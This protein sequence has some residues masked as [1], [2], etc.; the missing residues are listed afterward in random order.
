MPTDHNPQRRLSGSPERTARD[1]FPLGIALFV[2]SM[3]FFAAFFILVIQARLHPVALTEHALV[4]ALG[5]LAVGAIAGGLFISATRRPR[6]LF[7]HFAIALGLFAMT[8]VLLQAVR[9]VAGVPFDSAKLVATSAGVTMVVGSARVVYCV[10]RVSWGPR[11]A[12]NETDD[13]RSLNHVLNNA[14]TTIYTR[15]LVEPQG[16]A[17]LLDDFAGLLASAIP[18]QGTVLVPVAQELRLIENLAELAGGRGGVSSRV[19][20]SFPSDAVGLVPS[21]VLAT[22]F[23]NAV[24]HGFSPATGWDIEARYREKESGGFL[25]RVVN[26]SGDEAPA[27]AGLGSGIAMVRE[28]L[29][30]IY[31]GCHRFVSGP[32]EAHF[33]AEI[34]TW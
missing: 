20:L 21:L 2:G 32:R 25:L 11:A 30:R 8:A 28:Q 13:T 18:A 23:E 34:E 6:S 12:P 31:P 33:H 4:T 15:S 7:G 10:A 26:R 19:A 22:L 17:R 24:S 1:R 14:L 29:D 27:Q 9:I 5:N 3:V 16:T